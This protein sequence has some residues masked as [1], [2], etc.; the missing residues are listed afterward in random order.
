[1]PAKA[2]VIAIVSGATTLP[3]PPTS[4]AHVGHWGGVTELAFDLELWADVAVAGTVLELLGAIGKPVT[5]AD[6]DVNSVDTA[7]DTLTLTAHGLQSGD[8]PIQFTTSGTLPAGLVLLRDYWVEVVDVNKIKLHLTLSGVLAK[9]TAV[10]I[11]SAGSGTHTLVDV[12]SSTERLRWMSHG[13]LG[14]SV[15]GTVALDKHLGYSLRAAHRPPTLAY[16]I[17]GTVDAA[18]SAALRL[19]RPA[20]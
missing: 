5:I 1:M 13:L 11:T 10:D 4:W 17:V 3:S 14:N 9:T 18:T 8:G 2:D 12:V 15:N 20:S 19:V 6:D 7:A 16:A